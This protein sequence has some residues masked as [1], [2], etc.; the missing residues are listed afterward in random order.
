M[1]PNATLL[2]GL[3]LVL[4]PRSALAS[5]DYP[6]A[7]QNILR[8][9][10]PIPAP[11]TKGC[12]LCHKDEVGG[13]GTATRPFGI[14]LKKKAGVVGG[15]TSSLQA[16]L[17]YVYSHMTNSDGDPV[18]DYIELVVDGTDPNDGT[19]YAKPAPPEAD[20]GQGGS[21][22]GEGEGGQPSSGAFH[23][24]PPLPSG[25]L[26]PPYTHGCSIEPAKSPK[27]PA[28]A[29]LWV[30]ALGVLACRARRRRFR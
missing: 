30:G 7:L 23:P 27:G 6:Q 11:G 2:L 10:R 19:K 25:D 14:T 13:T 8:M 4:A 21:S 12:M 18:S 29:V 9:T 1:K 22:G 15:S 28:R 3:V 16:G 5:K 17:I 20:G 24:P 26:P